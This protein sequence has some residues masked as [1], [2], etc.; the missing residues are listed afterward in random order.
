M[1]YIIVG[2]VKVYLYKKQFNFEVE[3]NYR[4]ICWEVIKYIKPDAKSKLICYRLHTPILVAFC[5]EIR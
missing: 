4:V 5:V 3:F 2:L 1:H